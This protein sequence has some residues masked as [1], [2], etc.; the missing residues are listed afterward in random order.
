MSYISRL[1]SIIQDKLAL[2]TIFNATPALAG[3]VVVS[4]SSGNFSNS[5]GSLV[6]VTN[7]SVTITTTGRP[8][9]ILLQDDG[10]G[11]ASSIGASTS[12]QQTAA[13]SIEVLRGASLVSLQLISQTSPNSGLNGVQIPSSSFRVLDPVAAGTYTYSIKVQSLTSSM[14]AL[15]AYCK[16]V[17]YEI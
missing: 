13:M 16:L 2:R 14:T 4:S 7:L 6:S 9:M 3:G 11:N 10:S 17:A 5:S 15:V 12:S 8:V 1:Q